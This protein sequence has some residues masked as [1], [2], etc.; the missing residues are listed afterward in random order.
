MI[1]AVIFDLDGTLVDSNELHARAW[2]ETFEHFGKHFP[3]EKLRH[4]IGKGGDQYLPVFL[5]ESE[6]R[7]IGAEVEAFRGELYKKKYLSQVKAFPGVRALFEKIR[8]GGKKIALAS[9]GVADELAHYRKLAGIDDLVDCQTTKDDV[10]HSKPKPD[11]IIAALHQLENLRAEEA[12]LVGD[13]PYDVEAAK[14]VGVRTL[15]VLCGGFSE[16]EL[17]AA[18]A[19][20]IYRDP[21]DLLDRYQ[22]SLLAD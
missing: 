20:G 22:R 7:E 1:Q 16:D 18:G 15:A 6:Q 13:S 12:V 5:T 10:A 14:K 17:V 11:V 19:S 9:S 3:I 4:E 21:S 2:Q 8:E